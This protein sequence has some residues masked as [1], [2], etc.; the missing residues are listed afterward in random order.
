MVVMRFKANEIY[1][2]RIGR[3]SLLLGMSCIPSLIRL[4]SKPQLVYS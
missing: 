2:I 4:K 1:A 3:K